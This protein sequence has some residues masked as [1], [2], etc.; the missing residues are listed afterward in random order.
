MYLRVLSPYSCR[1]STLSRFM[2][3][4]VK[5]DIDLDNKEFQ[6][7]WKLIRFTRQSVFLT[8]KA[9]T[10]KSTFLKYIC[11]NTKKKFVVLAPTGIAAVNVGGV[12]MHSF[13]KIPFK[14]IL[15]DD[16]EFD[17]RHIRSRMKYSKEFIKLL[18]A[19]DL[20]IIDEISMVRADVIDF[21]DKILRTFSGNW[22]EPFGGKQMLFVGDL[23]QLEPVVTG[24]MR[25]ILSRFYPN[26]FFFS[27]RAFSRINMVPVELKKVYRQNDS[28]FVEMLDRMRSGC[29]TDADIMMLN[30]RLVRQSPK[31]DDRMVMTLATKRSMVDHINDAHLDALPAAEITYIGEIGGDFPENSLPTS[32]ELTVKAGAQIVFIRNDM[33]KRWVNGTIGKIYL[34]EEEK[35]VVQLEDGSFHNVEPVIW[36]NIKYEFDEKHNKVIEHE[37]GYFKQFPIKLAWALTIHKSQG[38]TFSDVIIDIGSG[39]FSGGQ[40]YVALSRCRSLEG[41]ELASTINKR[42]VFINPAVVNF[43]RSFNDSVLIEGALERA[44]ADDLYAKSLEAIN[45]DDIAGAFDFFIEAMRA[46]S[47]ID[48]QA[49]MRLV[50]SKL[51]RLIHYKKD[52]VR[53]SEQLDDDRVRFRKLASEYLSMARECRSEG[54]DPVPVFANYDKAISISPDY[55]DAWFE[56]GTLFFELGDDSA[57]EESFMKAYELEPTKVEVSYELSRLWLSR[58]DYVQAL[59]W[60]LIALNLDEER[61][62]T[63]SVLAEIYKNAGEENAAARHQELA[64]KFRRRNKK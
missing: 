59:D 62:S 26:P 48:N 61:S 60:G 56:K 50:R 58:G 39:T 11:A 22:R 13:F 21:V 28:A 53:L 47:E 41:M 27:A 5:Q 33:E 32:K 14:P 55:T 30:R 36:S 17:N 31:S 9:G 16:P 4:S 7:V 51:S 3:E 43:S 20:I 45:K 38:L 34:A 42:D 52:A 40:A 1:D 8:G 54:M 64:R 19:L 35:L 44:K 23:F 25:D 63:H 46:R 49:V 57:A 2:K 12:T 18:R 6:D 24:D 29:P 10:G 15:P 37:L